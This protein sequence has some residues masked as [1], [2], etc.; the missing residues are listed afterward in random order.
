MNEMI[1]PRPCPWCGK[2]PVVRET[3]NARNR[4]S[5]VVGC[6]NDACEVAP[7]TFLCP[8]RQEAVDTWNR[9]EETLA[10]LK[11]AERGG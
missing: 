4:K 6:C 8:T 9:Y 1:E 5:F 11:Q 2:A 10:K 7:E 3:R